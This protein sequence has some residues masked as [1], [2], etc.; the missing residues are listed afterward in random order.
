MVC[1]GRC[2]IQCTVRELKGALRG[3]TTCSA[4][5]GIIDWGCLIH[6][7]HDLA[8]VGQHDLRIQALNK[9]NT[10]L[11]SMRSVSYLSYR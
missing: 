11:S 1:M 2:L 10:Y 6:E 8:F 5:V 3:P 7:S 9:G 4:P